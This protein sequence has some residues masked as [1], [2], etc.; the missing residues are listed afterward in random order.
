MEELSEKSVS[1]TLLST[2]LATSLFLASVGT[3][4]MVKASNECGNSGY[5]NAIPMSVLVHDVA[6]GNVTVSKTVAAAGC[7]VLFNVTV[8]N[9]GNSSETPDLAIY[10]NLNGGTKPAICW[11]Y[12]VSL[13]GGAY[14]TASFACN[15]SG[16]VC[17]NYTITAYAEPVPGETDTADNTALTSLIVTVAGDIK[18]DFIVD[19]YDAI[20]VARAFNYT[21]KRPNWNPNADINDDN[22]VDIYDAIILANNFNRHA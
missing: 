17:G 6:V 3:T 15:T 12:E 1:F 19:I 13:T 11:Y 4:L 5:A 22:I 10:G 2:L 14:A 7:N 20:L 18:G 16:L 21:P 9:Q 8:I